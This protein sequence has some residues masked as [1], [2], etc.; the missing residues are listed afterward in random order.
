MFHATSSGCLCPM[1]GRKNGGGEDLWPRRPITPAS[2]QLNKAN[3]GKL[4][5][6]L[7]LEI[8]AVDAG[9]VEARLPVRA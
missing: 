7:G 5:G 3:E 2:R 1:T 6:W 4:P 8:T 9:L